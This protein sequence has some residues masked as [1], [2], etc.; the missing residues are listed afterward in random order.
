MPHF[1]CAACKLRLYSAGEPGDMVVDLMGELCPRCGSVLEPVGNLAQLVGFQTIT[2]RHDAPEHDASATHQ[3][4]ADGIRDLIA[5]TSATD[6]Q[7]W[8]DD[9][10]WADDG[11]SVRA[12]AQALPQ[13]R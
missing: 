9:G 7:A 10:R 12:E 13:L 1:K 3:A 11:G 4:I 5:G 8:L 2:S 6:V